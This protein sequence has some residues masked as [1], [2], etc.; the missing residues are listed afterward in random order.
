MLKV[1]A[2]VLATTAFVSCRSGSSASS[3]RTGDMTASLNSSSSGVMQAA[4]GDWIRNAR[5]C[6]VGDYVIVTPA[7]GSSGEILVGRRGHAVFY[8]D[9]HYTTV[10]DASGKRIVFGSQKGTAPGENNFLSYATFDPVQNAW[11]DTVDA[12]GDG[13]V[14]FRFVDRQGQEKRTEYS[15]DQRWLELVRRGTLKG[16]VLDGE[17][18][19]PAAAREKLSARKAGPAK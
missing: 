2:V 13:S 5:E 3:C 4:Y 8:S 7:E 14:D 11:I 10:M 18:M 12:G 15:V 16:V 1:A 6:K 17:F 19:T 9:A